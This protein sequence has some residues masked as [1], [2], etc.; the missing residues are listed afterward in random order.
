M[1]KYL[2]LECTRLGFSWASEKRVGGPVSSFVAQCCCSP[3]LIAQLLGKDVEV[4]AGWD[5]DC[6]SIL[7]QDL[8]VARVESASAGQVCM[9]CCCVSCKPQR[10]KRHGSAHT[11]SHVRLWHASCAWLYCAT[12]ATSHPV[13]SFVLLCALQVAVHEYVRGLPDAKPI[14]FVVGAFAHGQIDA[15]WVSAASA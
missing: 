1:T 5:W 4:G 13:T 15:P 7:Y 11:R 9:S 6:F 12:M 3:S 14:V 8:E 2:P 10:D